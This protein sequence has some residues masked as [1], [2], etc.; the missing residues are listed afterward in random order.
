MQYDDGDQETLGLDN[1][2][3]L[4]EQPTTLNCNTTDFAGNLQSNEQDVLSDMFEALANR[5]F[6]R[7]DAQA[8]VRLP[9][10]NSYHSRERN[11]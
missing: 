5:A 2:D 10:I 8:F 6:F 7:H 4:F 1:E 11:V 9:L 3:R